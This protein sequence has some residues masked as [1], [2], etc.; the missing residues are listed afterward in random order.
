MC[1]KNNLKNIL[2]TA[3]AVTM[4]G[5]ASKAQQLNT[6]DA[7]H[8]YNPYL[9]SPALA[10]MKDEKGLITNIH[11]RRISSNL[12][13]NPLSKFLT[14]DGRLGEGYGAGLQLLNTSAG[15]I[16][17]TNAKG[18]FSYHAK[19]KEG[20]VLHIGFSMGL[21]FGRIDMNKVIGQLNDPV[22]LA[23]KSKV[24]FDSDLG[25]AY[26][27]K[28]FLLQGTA[29]NLRRIFNSGLADEAGHDIAYIAISNKVNLSNGAIIT[30]RLIYQSRSNVKDVAGLGLSYQTG[31]M[32]V[33]FNAYVHTNSAYSAGLGYAFSKSFLLNLFY[34]KPGNDIRGRVS[35]QLEMGMRWKIK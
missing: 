27:N 16:S 13:G 7:K 28:N 30:P 9:S 8:E 34:S 35:E 32:P 5:Q 14:L 10:G 12:D 21:T 22:L 31:A 26:E 23:Y 25:L 11:Y 18:S 15:L 33:S 20:E 6:M 1:M 24:L 19:L 29:F 4:I 17:E 2:L 3:F